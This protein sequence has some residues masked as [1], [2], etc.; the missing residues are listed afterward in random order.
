MKRVLTFMLL[1]LGPWSPLFAA[2]D[3]FE[4]YQEE[5]TVQTGSHQPQRQGEAPATVYVVT[6]QEIKDSGAQTIWDALRTVP[7][8]D[9]IST[10]TGQ[11]E[12]SIRGLD[13]AN[14]NRTLILLDGKT[15]LNGYY[16]YLTW[17][18]L[19]ITLDDIDRIEVLEGP[20]SAVYGANAISGVINIITKTPQQ[21]NGG[22]LKYTAGERSTQDGSLVD[23]KQ[24]DHWGYKFGGGWDSTNRFEDA[25]EL[26]AQSGKF[27]ALVRYQGPEN[28]FW[29]A[30]GGVTNF[31]AQSTTGGTGTAIDKGLESFARVDG[32]LEDTQFRA[33]WNH[34]R[35]TP[36]QFN[37]LALG[38]V[39]QSFIDYDSYD[40]E[41]Q[42]F[43]SLPWRN[44]VVLGGNVR[45]NTSSS[46]TFPPGLVKEDLWAL[47]AEDKW[48]IADKWTLNASGRL[49]RHPY[50]PLQ[51]SPRGS[52]NY[53]PVPDQVF[54]ASGGTS[55]RYPTLLENYVNVNLVT[56]NPDPTS[57]YTT[58]ATQQLG[59]KS[60]SPEKI[61]SA[62][63]A[64]SGQFGPLKTNIAGFHYRINNLIDSG[65]ATIVPSLPPVF[66]TQ[67]TF[68]NT[69]DITA[70]GGEAAAELRLF[71]W[72]SS[73][74]NYSYQYLRDDPGPQIVSQQ[75]P[76][77][78]ANVGL[79]VKEAGW[80]GSLTADWVDKTE[81]PTVDLSTSENQLAPVSAY[82]LLNLH[83]GYAFKGSWEG[84]EAG[85]DV[86]N[87]LNHAHYEILPSEGPYLPGEGGEIIRQRITGTLSYKFR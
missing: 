8:V 47:F 4:F 37:P 5:A 49:D 38:G 77:H 56:P 20:A 22:D 3:L 46:S 15:V 12:V 23:G 65:P 72:L 1:V 19:P 21:L 61:E 27:N 2:D 71:S 28:S 18:S 29:S 67:E 87:L 41:L 75:S 84:F 45:E 80:N 6:A 36:E 32:R 11:G 44:S 59:N 43:I 62:E 76:R 79:R 52:L 30:S 10:R 64:H 40:A 83:V 54:R 13:R 66:T 25:S 24:T 35:T 63:I 81:W 48:D 9:V 55:F 82:W 42:Q 33:Y 86:F 73:F 39:E 26:A 31:E 34:G 68:I 7:G 74:A 53:A 16:D 17:E 69:G 50:T 14:N 60:L 70:W 58:L 85:L 57:P 51:F 78:K